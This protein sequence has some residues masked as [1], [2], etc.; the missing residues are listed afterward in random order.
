MA[1]YLEQIYADLS[2]KFQ[3]EPKGPILIEVFN[4]HEMFSGRVVALPDLHTV[5]ACTGRMFAMASPNGKGIRKPFNWAQGAAARNG[6]HFQP[7]TD[8]FP[9]AALADGRAGRQ[10]RGLSPA[11]A[12]ERPACASACRRT[13]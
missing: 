8:A 3:Y 11:A 13:T 1:D 2:E 10:Q 7:G 5:G 4:N 6:P 9:D 12:V